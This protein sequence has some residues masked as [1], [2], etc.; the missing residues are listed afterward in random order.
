MVETALAIPIVLLLILG[1]FEYG[2]FFLVRNV[3]ANAA[4]EGARYAVIH[5]YDKTTSDIQNYV[6]GILGSSTAQLTGLAIQVYA[7]DSLDNPLTGVSWNNAIFGSGIGVQIDGDYS[8]ITPGFLLMPNMVH[9]RTASI[10][11]SEAN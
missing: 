7:A 5:T 3:I 9:M 4:R 2:R 8:P 10:M 1:I 11:N 6:L